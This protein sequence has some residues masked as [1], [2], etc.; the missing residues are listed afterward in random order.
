MAETAK[1]RGENLAQLINKLASNRS[2]L[3][4]NFKNLTLEVAEFKAKLNESI[5]LNMLY[6]SEK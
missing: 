4:L 5:V 2:D 3:E 6:A 1:T